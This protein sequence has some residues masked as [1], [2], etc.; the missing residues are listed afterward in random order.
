[1][2]YTVRS[3]HLAQFGGAVEKVL[4][5]GRWVGIVYRD[6]KPPAEV[7]EMLAALNRPAKVVPNKEVGVRAVLD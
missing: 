5:E 1:M 2:G 6:P 4:V 7:D 3:E